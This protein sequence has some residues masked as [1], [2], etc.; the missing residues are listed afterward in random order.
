MSAVQSA[1]YDW[2]K[3]T[4]TLRLDPE[5]EKRK[6][7]RNPAY[8]MKQYKTLNNRC[9]ELRKT[10]NHPLLNYPFFSDLSKEF[11][12]KSCGKYLNIITVVWL[13]PSAI[14]PIKLKE[15]KKLEVMSIS[16]QY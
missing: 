12:V 5:D 3:S 9:M 1:I 8:Q 14:Y 16:T 15:E 7:H 10:C 11:I 6:L 2:V 4:G 13:N